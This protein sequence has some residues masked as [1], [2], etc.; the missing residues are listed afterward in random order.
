MKITTVHTE[1]LSEVIDECTFNKNFKREF[2]FDSSEKRI[3][4]FLS[5]HSTVILASN[6]NLKYVTLE[7]GIDKDGNRER[8]VVLQYLDGTP[9]KFVRITGCNIKDIILKVLAVC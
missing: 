1:I 9:N 2:I 5:Q 6:N 4:R 8:F 7:L 3:S